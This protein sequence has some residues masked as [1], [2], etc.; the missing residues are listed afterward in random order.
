MIDV[1]DSMR[2]FLISPADLKLQIRRRFEIF[3]AAFEFPASN[4]LPEL[5]MAMKR[6]RTNPAKCVNT[7]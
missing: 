1:D 3:S 2:A 4:I 5:S 7:T 6:R